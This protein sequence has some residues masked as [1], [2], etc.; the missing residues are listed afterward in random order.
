[1]ALLTTTLLRSDG[2]RL[3]WP[4]T[5]LAAEPL[6]NLSRSDYRREG[7]RL[8]VEGPRPP[9]L[10][11]KLA[12]AAIAHVRHHPSEFAG[13]GAAAAARGG[14]CAGTGT[15][16]AQSGGCGSGG[17]GG[18]VSISVGEVHGKVLRVTVHY[19]LAHNGVDLERCCAAR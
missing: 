6:L 18:A 16:G 17:T 3:C 2:A 12:A 15:G 13:S 8:T 9:D 7:L 5:K 11:Q 14:G 1:M 4:N 19:Q 10:L